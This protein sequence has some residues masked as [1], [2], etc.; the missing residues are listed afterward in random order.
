MIRFRERLPPEGW[1]EAAEWW[2]R[3]GSWNGV[4]FVEKNQGPLFRA[5]QT[6]S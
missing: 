5:H 3:M 4:W 2:Y 6:L 1:E